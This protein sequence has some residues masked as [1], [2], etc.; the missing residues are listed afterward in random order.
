[1]ECKAQ[2]F[3]CPE[4]KWFT[5]GSKEPVHIGRV[6]TILRL[7]KKFIIN[8]TE[9]FR[10]KCSNEH[11]Y[12]CVAK[13]EIREGSPYS[14]IYRKAGKQFSSVIESEYVDVTSCIRDDEC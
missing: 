10:C 1:M 5:K 12:K 7:K 3:P 4:I 13:N 8:K 14:E 11:Q 9:I 6:Y 2:G